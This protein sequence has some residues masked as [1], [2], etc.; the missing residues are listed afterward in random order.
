MIVTLYFLTLALLFPIAGLTVF[1]CLIESIVKFGLWNV[2]KTVFAPLYDP[3]GR[4]IWILL[5]VFGFIGLCAAGL[6][7]ESRPYGL[8]V[9]GLSGILCSTF[10]FKVFPRPWEPGSYF[11]FLPGLGG[12]GLSIFCLLQLI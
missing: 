10:V 2:F 1:G 8:A 12:I 3:F 4:G 6:F 7:P 9:M 5:T 11:L